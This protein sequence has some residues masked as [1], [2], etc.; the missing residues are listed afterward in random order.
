MM[1]RFVFLILTLTLSFAVFAGDVNFISE[2]SGATVTILNPGN[3][4]IRSGLVYRAPEEVSL[5][6]RS[7]LYQIEFSLE[8]Y[9]TKIVDVAYSSRDQDVRVK[10]EPLE[11]TR[12]FRFS[13]SPSG[14]LVLVDGKSVGN[15]PTSARFVFSRSSSKTPWSTF[16]VEYLL[17]GYATNQIQIDHDS[18]TIVPEVA[19]TRLRHEKTF[20]VVAET[21]T[22]ASLNATVMK[23]GVVVGATPIDV[24]YEFARS[25]PGAA[26]SEFEISVGIEHAY[27]EK[28]MVVDYSTGGELKFKLLPV[29]EVPVTRYFPYTE[30]TQLGPELAVDTSTAIGILDT[31]DLQSPAVDLRPVTNFQ[32][33][34][35]SLQALNS[36]TIMPSGQDLIYS[37]TSQNQDQSYYANLYTKSANDTSFRT[38]RLTMGSRFFDT[39]PVMSLEEGSNLVVFQSNRGP[40]ARWDISSFRLN[41]GRVVGGIQQLTRDYQF[42]DSPS[43]ASEHQE[44]YFVSRDERRV[45]AEPMICF[46]RPDGSSLTNLGETGTMLQHT[47]SGLIYFVRKSQDN[48]KKQ[49]YSITTEGLSFSSVINDVVFNES[50]CFDPQMS[51]D[52]SKLLFVSDNGIDDKERN[53]NDIFIYELDTGRIQRLTF[54]GSDDIS[55]RWSPSEPGVIFFMSNRGGVYNIWRMQIVEA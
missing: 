44:I 31:R 41:E 17:D 39:R 8:G 50:N 34:Q 22:G 24:T 25:N 55:P 36:Y 29:T 13:S 35:G 7:D 53:N 3:I 9:E 49:I 16:K 45:N 38:T 1:K 2:P 32:R 33:E 11:D 26:W 10:L 42:N 18:G 4:R 47:H 54:T 40:I 46:V 19:L 43:F 52:G 6:R 20:R 48:Q 15:T 28:S 23:D 21:A 12:E 37:V 27:V 30:M 14:A 51:P 5:P